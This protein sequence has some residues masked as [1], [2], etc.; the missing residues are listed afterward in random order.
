MSWMFPRALITWRNIPLSPR[1][2]EN[3]KLKI[4]IK[5]LFASHNGM[6]GSPIITA[7]LHDAPEFSK[8]SRP[9]VARLMREMGLKCRTVRKFAVTTDSKHSEPV[10]PNLLDRQFSV[11]SPNQ[12]WVT[13]ITYLRIGGKWHYLTVF[14]D[15]FSR[16]VVGWDLSASLKRTSAIGAL[17]KAIL[18]R[19]PGRGGVSDRSGPIPAGQLRCGKTQAARRT[20]W[21]APGL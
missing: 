3:E 15:L 2:I 4:G 10:A 13:D 12:V 1:R 19:R 5:E 14:I 21:P 20:R 18:R 11:S 8:V 9:H 7:D 6:V 16:N 17:N